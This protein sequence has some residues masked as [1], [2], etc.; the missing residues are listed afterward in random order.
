M[1]LLDEKKKSRHESPTCL[2]SSHA[3]VT[4]SALDGAASVS[5]HPSVPGK[6]RIAS[7]G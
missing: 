1:L 3:A 5:Q 7:P 6:D 2:F 4:C